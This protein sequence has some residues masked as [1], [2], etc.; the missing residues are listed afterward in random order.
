MYTQEQEA[1]VPK[2][3]RLLDVYPRLKSA[4]EKNLLLKEVLAKA[5]YK[6]DRSDRGTS[7]AFELVIY[8]KLPYV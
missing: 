2:V 1:F 8:P 7:D 6:K 5:V 3:E 4:K